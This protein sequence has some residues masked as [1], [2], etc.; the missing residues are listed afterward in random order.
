MIL[1]AVLCQRKTLSLLIVMF[2][3]I[4]GCQV[5]P[6]TGLRPVVTA[7]PKQM[8]GSTAT[9][10]AAESTQSNP[11]E[12]DSPTLI[13]NQDNANQ[14]QDPDAATEPTP[15]PIIT[16]EV[17]EDFNWKQLPILPEIS[18]NAFEIYQY[19]QA[20]GRD[21][22]HVSVIGDCQAIPFVFLGKYGLK[23]YTLEPAD[24]H[25][26]KMIAYY[27]DSFA[28]EGNAVRGGFTAAAVLSSVRA[29]PD[30]CAAGE[31]PLDCEWREYNPSV[32]FINL[33]TWREEGTVDRYELYLEK[34][35]EYTI[36]RGT[37][38]I[39]IMKA[40][41]AEAETHVINPAMARVAYR[42]DIPIINFWQAAQYLDNLGIDPDRDGFHLSEAG[43]DRKQILALRTLY[44]VWSQTRSESAESI[45]ADGDSEP[46]L[47]PTVAAPTPRPL[48]QFDF[49]CAG[50]CIVYDLWATTNTG[51]Q[52][53][54]IMELDTESRQ[55]H[56]AS[57]PGFS[58]QDLAPSQEWFLINHNT[59]LYLVERSTGQSQMLLENLFTDGGTSAYF[60]LDETGV[61]AITHRETGVAIIRYDLA[62]GD[63][64][65]LYEAE[66]APIRLVVY[67]PTDAV[68]W[69]SGQCP[70]DNYCQ[71]AA[72][73]RTDLVNGITQE[74]T[75]KEKIIFS[76]DGLHTAF[77]DPMHA[78]EFNYYHN[79]I[80]LYEETQAGLISRRLFAFPHPGGFRVH[81]EVT[82]YVFSPDGS[83]LFVLYDEYSDYF[84]KSLALHFYLEDLQ[85]RVVYEYGETEGAYGS[86][87]P[88]AVW[89]PDGSEVFLLLVNT[90]NDR[91]YT[92]EFFRKDIN[93]RFS[94][95]AAVGDPLPLDGYA[96]FHRAFWVKDN[97]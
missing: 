81:P 2:I 31:T 20:L 16:R 40:D 96:V 33:E 55:Q 12:T 14:Q 79:P 66:P 34:I 77:R 28:R 90:A 42:Y 11:V 48:P 41:K 35:V 51:I 25:L 45:D 62:T 89:S 71:T 80:L 21:P 8:T 52:S 76:S 60:S 4:S 97:Q 63:I 67:R 17:P 38:P 68:V 36:E 53:Q 57:E 5:N 58:L 69:E 1:N 94:P 27:R 39:L 84:E 43:Y 72:Y 64:T 15:R 44:Q 91:D 18:T 70:A 54:G 93:D 19:G 92:L 47:T 88:Q 32:A 26:E 3:L 29:D 24:L 37:L 87:K 9:M 22:A 74:I 83:R 86:L 30:Q 73:W 56:L 10:A 7:T 59:N 82:D 13:G 46:T 75:G 50:S 85:N 61:I 6:E 95:L 78:D 23:Q 65:P 49:Q